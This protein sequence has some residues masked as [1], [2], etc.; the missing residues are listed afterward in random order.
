M[1]AL[2]HSFRT[3]GP[4]LSPLRFIHTGC[5]IGAARHRNA[6]QRSRGGRAGLGWAWWGLPRARGFGMLRTCRL[7][8]S[9]VMLR[10]DCSFAPVSTLLVSGLPSAVGYTCAVRHDWISM[11]LLGKLTTATHFCTVRHQQSF[12]GCGWCWTLLPVWSAVLASTNNHTSPSWCDSLATVRQRILYNWPLLPSTLSATLAQPTF[13]RFA[14]RSPTSLVGYTCD[15]SALPKIIICWFLEP[16]LSLADGVSTL[17]LQSSELAGQ[18]R[19]G[20]KTHLFVQSYT[21]SSVSISY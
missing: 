3:V 21:S 1:H 2:F 11:T 16:K 15:T 10:V 8:S 13:D 14:C 6:T 20:L 17:Q 12:V 19:D 4:N 18:F 9:G 7:D 5:N